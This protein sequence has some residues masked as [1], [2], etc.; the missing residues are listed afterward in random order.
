MVIPGVEPPIE[1]LTYRQELV[2]R[3]PRLD[4]D[5]QHGGRTSSVQRDP[6]PRTAQYFFDSTSPA[7][8][9]ATDGEVDR[10]VDFQIQLLNMPNELFGDANPVGGLIALKVTNG[11]SGVISRF[12]E[13][14]A[15][16]NRRVVFI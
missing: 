9:V 6:S 15:A 1:F 10:R 2:G 4:L 3:N 11:N 16:L 8:P 5:T 7:L 13:V 12:V 14:D